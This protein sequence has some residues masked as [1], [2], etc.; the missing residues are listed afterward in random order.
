MTDKKNSNPPRRSAW[1]EL[2]TVQKSRATRPAPATER[3]RPRRITS[4]KPLHTTI[5]ESDED[6][7]SKWRERFFKLTGKK[8][9]LGEIAGLLARICDDR[10]EALALEDQPDSIEEFVDLLVGE[11]A[12][13]SPPKRK[14]SEA[15]QNVA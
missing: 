3:G 14:R 7:L 4:L 9:T 6:L 8:V 12:R 2:Y 13:V 5:S 15:G 10:L 11:P 1:L